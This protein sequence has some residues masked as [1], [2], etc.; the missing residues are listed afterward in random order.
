MDKETIDGFIQDNYP[1]LAED[2]LLADGFEEAF[3]GVMISSTAPKDEFTFVL[4][5]EMLTKPTRKACQVRTQLL[6]LIPENQVMGK[7][8]HIKKQF[9][10]EI[11]E[12]INESVLNIE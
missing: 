10:R 6:S 11:L 2:I 3:I 5:N 12:K 8:G 7:H 4:S 1:D 9:L